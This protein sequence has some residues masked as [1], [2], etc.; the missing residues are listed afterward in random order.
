[1]RDRLLKVIRDRH[2]GAPDEADEFLDA[3]LEAMV[4]PTPEMLLAA[5][6]E[7]TTANAWRAMVKRIME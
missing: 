3:I 4:D 1:M 2:C 6:R 7:Y 5:T